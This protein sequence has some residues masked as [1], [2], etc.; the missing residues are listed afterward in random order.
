MNSFANDLV[1]S[2]HQESASVLRIIVDIPLSL[3]IRTGLTGSKLRKKRDEGSRCSFASLNFLAGSTDGL[4]VGDLY[5]PDNLFLGK[6]FVFVDELQTLHREGD[7]AQNDSG[8]PQRSQ[9]TGS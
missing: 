2:N 9:N 1:A 7:C 6:P 5:S 8:P 3:T 4:F